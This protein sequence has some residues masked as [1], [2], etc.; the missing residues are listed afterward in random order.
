MHL[1]TQA[2]VISNVSFFPQ[3]AVSLETKMTDI[4]LVWLKSPSISTEAKPGQF[5]MIRCGDLSLPRP[6]SIHRVQNDRVAI[7]FAV[8]KDGKGTRWLSERRAGDAVQIFGP[9][10]NGFEVRP[11]SRSLLLVAG[12]MGIAPLRFLAEE[13]ASKRID[14][15]LLLGAHTSQLLYPRDQ[16]PKSI[17][18]LVATDDGSLGHAGMITSLLP[19]ATR[20]ADQVFACGPLAMYRDMSLNSSRFGLGE[21]SV[22]VS[23]EAVMGCGHGVCYGC[24]V[25]T[26]QGQKQVCKDGPVFELGDVSWD[27]LP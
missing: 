17:K 11:A 22:Q 15:T 5:I 14:V 21:K 25:G 9:L 8:L 3:T 24:T 19:D 7:M 6:L 26:R 10:G 13:A 18:V 12:G 27:T 4:R 16:L 23:I 2:T 20:E 1:D